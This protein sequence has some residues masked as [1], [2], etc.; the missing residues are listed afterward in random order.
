[1]VDVRLV[2]A[3]H[4][5]LPAM[6][7]QATFR[8]DLYYPLKVFPINI[9]A[10]R[11]RTED[12]PKL[13]HHFTALYA[14]RMNKKINTIPSETMEALVRYRWPGNVRELRNFIERAVILSP[15]T[16]LH[17][18][19]AELEPFTPPGRSSV[20]MTGLDELERDHIIQAL[21]LS[22]WV[23]GGRNGA[24]QRLGMKR[25]SLVYKMQKHRIVRPSSSREASVVHGRVPA[26]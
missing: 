10:L 21:E 17:A 26:V 5:D 25:T 18:P 19:I 20:P 22:N 7:K 6:V 13:V 14:Q 2:A 4:R 12:I 15:H 24:A 1:M 16:R 23:V 11:E 3:T 8:D 9:P